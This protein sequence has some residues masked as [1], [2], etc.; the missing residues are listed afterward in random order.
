MN[1]DTRSAGNF[2]VSPWIEGLA[3]KYGAVLL[4][5]S[6]GTAAKYGLTLGEGRP[7]TWREVASDLLLV[8]MICLIAAFGATRLGAEVTTISV[9]SAFLAVS[10][11]RAIRML[12]DRF[13]QRVS[14]EVDLLGKKKGE[15][16]Q[17]SQ[18]EISKRRVVDG[19][20]VL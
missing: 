9:M 14:A 2:P 1:A 15:L 6:I 12:R 7:I 20:D 8:P 18:M 16:R 17:L 5:V 19:E 11:D 13:M 10:S 4:G 3:A